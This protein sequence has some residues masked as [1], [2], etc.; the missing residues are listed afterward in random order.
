MKKKISGLVIIASICLFTFSAFMHST[1][2]YQVIGC[3]INDAGVSGE[4]LAQATG[5]LQK[6]K[7][8]S[9][10]ITYS[11]EGTR[12]LTQRFKVGGACFEVVASTGQPDPTGIVSLFKL[13]VGKTN[14][15]FSITN[16]GTTPAGEISFQ[17]TA[18]DGAPGHFKVFLGPGASLPQGEYVF[19]DRSTI[20]TDGKITVW[21]F[22]VD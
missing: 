1:L 12:A 13:T 9:S 18:V 11:F 21:A 10:A 5:T 19:A 20:T 6:G 8:K 16:D 14:R 3:G 17:L 15:S 22:G 4:L 7:G 2:G